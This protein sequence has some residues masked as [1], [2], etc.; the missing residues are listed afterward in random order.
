MSLLAVLVV[1]HLLAAARAMATLDD[2]AA[3]VAHGDARSGDDD[4]DVRARHRDPD[5]RAN[6]RSANVRAN[7]ADDV[8]AVVRHVADRAHAKMRGADVELDVT[9]RRLDGDDRS[10]V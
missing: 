2:D 3:L 9:R 5:H 1:A 8:R 6:V 4:A 10:R 7:V